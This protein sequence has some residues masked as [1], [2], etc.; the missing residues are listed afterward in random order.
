MR[1]HRWFGTVFKEILT[2]LGL[3]VHTEFPVMADPP[4]ADLVIIRK[5]TAKWTPEQLG[6]LP[7]GLRESRAGH[8][9]A[10]FKHTESLTDDSFF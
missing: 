2:P 7:D 8:T 6:Y 3:E 1:L 5:K 10:E 4:E 9:I